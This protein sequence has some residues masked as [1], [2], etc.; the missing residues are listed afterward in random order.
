MQK[1]IVEQSVRN[2]TPLLTKTGD[3]DVLLIFVM[4]KAGTFAGYYNR[5]NK[6]SFY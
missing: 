5:G 4:Q 6:G 3:E 2:D 1:M